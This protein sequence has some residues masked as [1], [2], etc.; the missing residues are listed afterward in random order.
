MVVSIVN[1]WAWDSAPIDVHGPSGEVA[2]YT[3]LG[4]G[5]RSEKRITRLAF[6]TSGASAV[7][8]YVLVARVRPGGLGHG[9]TGLMS[10]VMDVFPVESKTPKLKPSTTWVS[11][12]VKAEL[13]S[14]MPPTTLIT[15]CPEFGAWFDPAWGGGQTQLY[16]C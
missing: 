15:W 1:G 14:L 10:T 5:T 9:L 3:V 6:L 4:A 8:W 12:S 2:L 7:M 13:A 11:G 16:G